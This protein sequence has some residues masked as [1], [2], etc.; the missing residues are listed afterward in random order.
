MDRRT[1][2]VGASAV[3]AV[4]VAGYVGGY[5]DLGSDDS[6][7]EPDLDESPE[8]LSSDNTP[9]AVTES[10]FEAF[11]AGNRKKQEE[12]L[13][14]DVTG[15]VSTT[16]VGEVTINEIEAR[17]I[18]EIAEQDDQS[19]TEDELENTRQDIQ[20]LTDEIGVADSTHVYFDYETEAHGSVDG[21]LFVVEDDG[22]WKIYSRGV[23]VE[24]AA[25]Q[26]ATQEVSG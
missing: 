16:E 8:E 5:V 25:A 20:Q 4:G 6:P 1:F 24:S 2:I 18:A 9:E 11:A 19:I 15:E 14:E 26:G 23:D 21:Y 12:L 13:H 17:T 7:E 10:F 22:S 3:S